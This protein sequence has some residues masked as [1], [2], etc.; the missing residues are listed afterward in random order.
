VVDNINA[1]LDTLRSITVRRRKW[2]DAWR[3]AKAIKN[4][5]IPH[6]DDWWKW[7][8]QFARRITADRKYD[9]ETNINETTAGFGT[10][11]DACAAG[12]L[13]WQ[14]VNK[15]KEREL[16]DKLTR[17]QRMASKFGLTIQEVLP[18]LGLLHPNALSALANQQQAADPAQDQ[19]AK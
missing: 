17:A 14:D 1:T 10:Q 12:G 7:E 15:Q 13:W 16:D 19:P 5:R 6:N 18:H 11:A 8:Y 9:S 3:I 2:I 4:K